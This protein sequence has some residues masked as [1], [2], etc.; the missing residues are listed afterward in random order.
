MGELIW[1]IR[2][3][4]RI[5]K[6]TGMSW[7]KCDFMFAW[8]TSLAGLECIDGDWKNECPIDSADE[9]MSYWEE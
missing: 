5:M 7:G 8:E 9:E 6:R 2:Y 4:L 3:T 1:R